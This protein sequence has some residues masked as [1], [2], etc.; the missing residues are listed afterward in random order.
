MSFDNHPLTLQQ[1]FF[2]IFSEVY[3]Y[4]TPNMAFMVLATGLYI[5]AC[6]KGEECIPQ[7]WVSIDSLLPSSKLDRPL[8]FYFS[9]LSSKSRTRTPSEP[10]SLFNFVFLRTCSTRNSDS[11]SLSG[12]SL[13]FLSP[14]VTRSS[15]WQLIHHTTTSSV[16]QP[17]SSCSHFYSSFTGYSIPQWLRNLVSECNFKAL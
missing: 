16:L 4:V 8:T 2:P 5:N 1:F 7:T 13:E 11:Y 10:S 3:G 17:T 12:T 6:C 15:T 14:T 9:L